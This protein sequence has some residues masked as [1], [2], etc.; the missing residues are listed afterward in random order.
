MFLG[1]KGKLQHFWKASPC[2]FSSASHQAMDIYPLLLFASSWGGEGRANMEGR[3]RKSQLRKPDSTYAV[4][5]RACTIPGS[6]EKR[7]IQEKGLTATVQ[8]RKAHG[9]NFRH[10]WEIKVRSREDCFTGGQGAM[11]QHQVCERQKNWSKTNQA[12]VKQ[13]QDTQ[14]DLEILLRN[15]LVSSRQAIDFWWLW[16]YFQKP[17]SIEA[18]LLNCVLQFPPRHWSVL[19]KV[20]PNKP[21]SSNTYWRMEMAVSQ[22]PGE[23]PPASAFLVVY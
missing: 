14:S 17:V 1:E 13:K 3:V 6:L 18:Q 22:S 21:G 5:S 10:S 4:R 12:S 9:R 7:Q 19:I 23:K 15:K 16:P 8:E 20:H 11:T 2:L